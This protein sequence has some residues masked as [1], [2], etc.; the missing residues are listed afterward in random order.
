M[1]QRKAWFVWHGVNA[2]GQKVSGK[3]LATSKQVLHT[4]L[5]QQRIRVCAMR[6]DFSWRATHMQARDIT[7]FAR[8]LATLLH[9]G[10]PLLQSLEVIARAQ[11]DSTTHACVVQLKAQI[12]GG[13]ALHLALRQHMGFDDVFCN[14]VQV[15][16][17]TGGLDALLEGIA[18]QREKAQAL[19]SALRS[20]MVYPASVL[21]VALLVS[22]L[23]LWFVVPAFESMFASL[24]A[25]LPAM[26]RGLI[27]LS[28][29]LQNHG[30]PLLAAGLLMVVGCQ[31]WLFQQPRWQHAWQGLVLHLPLFGALT[32]EA[33][34]AR[35]S[36]T[37]AT[38]LQ[39]GIALSEALPAV[40]PVVGNMHYAVATRQMHAQLLQGQ[41]LSGALT[42]YAFLFQPMLIQMCEIGEASGTLDTLLDKAADHFEASV[43]RKVAQ[44]SVLVEPLM[45]LLLGT[46]IGSMVLA[47]YL[48]VFQMGQ[49]L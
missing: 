13:Q 16:E 30:L 28:A 9:A 7:A 24:H 3:Q 19:Q 11:P 44:L 8:R 42:Q 29:F 15:G 35:F 31:R 25:E 39:A 22:A 14:L 48:P 43:S 46:L 2:R 18:H 49:A 41:S 12:E 10:I 27:A 37:L 17:M 40:A 5:T 34:M 36:R 1:T 47:L 38:L 26:T 32:R 45:M 20:A 33:C 23:L 4:Q 21:T 6:R